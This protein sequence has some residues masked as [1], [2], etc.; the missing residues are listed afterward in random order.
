MLSPVFG[1]GSHC[2]CPDLLHVIKEAATSHPC[3]LASSLRQPVAHSPPCSTALGLPARDKGSLV[4]LGSGHH[5]ML[6]SEPSRSVGLIS[7]SRA[8]DTCVFPAGAQTDTN[9]GGRAVRSQH[10]LRRDPSS[11]SVSGEREKTSCR[12]RWR[13]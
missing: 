7:R 2:D 3:L 6:P 10:P 11:R 13:R 1:G 4:T 5:L 8:W 9:T 12:L